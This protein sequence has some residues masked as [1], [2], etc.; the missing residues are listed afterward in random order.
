MSF[1]NINS[2]AQTDSIIKTHKISSIPFS[3]HEFNSPIYI[4]V[5]NDSSIILTSRGNTNL[6]NNPGGNFSKQNASM[7]LF[8]PDSNFIFTAKIQADLKEIYDV[9]A[10]VLY[11]NQ[12]KWA[13]LCYENSVKKKPTVVSVV[14]NKY[15]DDCNSIETKNNYIYY[16]IVK[17]GNEISFHCSFDKDRWSLIRHFNMNF[18]DEK[19]QIGFAVHSSKGD[20]FTA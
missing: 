9:A 15:S 17:K 16:A 20:Q 18:D 5:K 7:L 11:Q 1:Y 8:H 19:L 14:T 2:F 12:Y 3:L 10:L 6:F 13:K 4:E